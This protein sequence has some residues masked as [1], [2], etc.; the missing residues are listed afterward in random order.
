MIYTYNVNIAGSRMSGN[1]QRSQSE[2]VLLPTEVIRERLEVINKEIRVARITYK[3]W[4][5]RSQIL[6]A[7]SVQLLDQDRQL[8]DQEDWEAAFKITPKSVKA[9]KECLHWHD[10]LCKLREERFS[11]QQ[12]LE[13][14]DSQ[15][16]R[17]EQQVKIT[18]T[19]MQ[20]KI[21]KLKKVTFSV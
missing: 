15:D 12:C 3:R 14:L 9:N 20:Q 10:H 8:M 21:K 7:K 2:E 19:E 18:S 13:R 11:L 16:V 4:F 1:S 17:G 5:N 6:T